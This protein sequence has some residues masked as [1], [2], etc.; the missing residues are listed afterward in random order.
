MSAH[1]AFFGDGERSFAL[2]P[3][4]IRELERRTGSGIGTL[5][6][7]F[8]EGH[9][10]HSALVEIIRLSLIGGGSTPKEAAELSDTYAANRPLMESFPIAA[11]VLQSIWTGSPVAKTDEVPANG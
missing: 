4:L 9:F 7:R 2:T 6:L 3:D 10:H 5:C 1:T 8:G 11:A